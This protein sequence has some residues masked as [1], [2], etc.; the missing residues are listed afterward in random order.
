MASPKWTPPPIEKQETD[1]KTAVFL[2]DASASMSSKGRLENGKKLVRDSLKELDGWHTGAIIYASQIM[3]EAMPA[4]STGQTLQLVDDWKSTY[5]CGL[6]E[7][8]LRKAVSMLGSRGVRRLVIA[9]DFQLGDWSQ[10]LSI[11]PQDIN[12]SFLDVSGKKSV[13]NVAIADTTCRP[14]SQNRL[15][16][17]V[18]VRN[19][20]LSPQKR[21]ISLTTPGNETLTQ[22]VEIRPKSVARCPFVIDHW[23][24][25]G[26]GRAFLS[27]DDY[28]PDDSR[29]FWTAGRPPFSIL[30]VPSDTAESAEELFFTQKAFAAG[31]A[32]GL[33]DFKCSQATV[34]TL[35]YNRLN[36]FQ[37]IFL[38]S[39]AEMMDGA[40][41]EKLYDYVFKGGVLFVT[42]GGS[43]SI[44]L[45]NLQKGAMP[46]AQSS[47]IAGMASRNATLGV[48]SVASNSPLDSLFGDRSDHDLYLF[49]IRK[50]H[51]LSPLHETSTL[52]QSLEQQPLLISR[53]IGKGAV[54]FFAFGFS[55]EWSDFP[56][57]NSFL[58]LLR[59]LTFASVP[60]G[61]GEIHLSCG[62]RHVLSDG[63]EADTSHP[64]LFMDGSVRCDISLPLRESMTE[65]INLDDL[66]MMLKS[67]NS[68]PP[69]SAV[70]PSEAPRD[71]SRWF[72]WL[73]AFLLLLEILL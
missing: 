49:P 46:L 1:M 48:G 15:Q 67:G 14:L 5:C 35:D 56:L 26:Q 60:N 36:D 19:F 39:S 58:P 25:D 52:M 23:S 27:P 45:R 33:S 13:D 47:G 53:N 28:P 41:M 63:K 2:L 31:E 8:P 16:I 7:E 71:F 3:S 55:R 61:F 29:L 69:P 42:G 4:S 24:P 9:S 37:A 32:D 70:P 43:A 72:A 73:A 51:R 11:V 62:D 6:T 22:D 57:T 66:R 18:S 50:H 21:T 65:S 34:D 54:Y 12:I 68:A 59:E 17:I 44:A 20:S 38:L 40:S 64:A 10:K 30:L